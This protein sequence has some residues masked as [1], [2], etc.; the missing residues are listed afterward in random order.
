MG[1]HAFL[2][3]N[4]DRIWNLLIEMNGYGARYTG[5]DAHKSYI[6]LIKDQ[7]SMIKLPV[8]TDK[9]QFNRWEAEKA[10]LF[11][12]NGSEVKSIPITG[13]YPYSGSTTEKG[14]SGELVY[15]KSR[16]MLKQAKGKIAVIDVNNIVLP[17]RLIFR[18]RKPAPFLPRFMRHCVVGSTLLGPNLADA[19]KCGV[20]G[21]IC[22]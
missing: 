22:V 7:L 4:G 1:I 13:Y 3:E 6:Q 19:A 18:T 17:T 21:I 11:V 8:F 12:E 20:L 5:N 16:R 10:A 9:H 2:K 14:L 15:C